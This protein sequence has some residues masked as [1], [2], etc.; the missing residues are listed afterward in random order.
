MAIALTCPQC[1]QTFQLKDE[2]AG[3]KV[4][5]PECESV[6]TVPEATPEPDDPS[7][8]AD[9]L[10]H[11]AF[12]RDRFFFRQKLLTI[13]EKYSVTDDQERPILFIERPAHFVK[14]LLAAFAAV[15]VFFI[16]L[17]VALVSSLSLQN[18]QPKGLS[19]AVFVIM[20]LIGVVA[21]VWVAFTLSPKRHISF[22]ADDT[23]THLLLQVLQDKKFQPIVSTY[24]VT[25]PEIGVVGHI[26]KNILTNILRKRWDVLD[27]DGTLILLA[28]EDSL[29]LSLLRRFLGPLFG[30]LRTNFVLMVP[31]PGAEGLIRGEFN[32]KF[33]LVDRYVLDLSLDRPRMIDRRLAAALGVMLDTGEHR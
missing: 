3:R 27:P 16:G 26:K 15:A 8:D 25:I 32:R 12:Q 10:M 28:R 29:L 17:M 23:K 33:T 14:S 30:F 2:M 9:P 21:T 7:L 13:G 1:S 4:R 18:V 5:C 20:L 22:Y 6:L 11:P 24:T 31:R 19:V